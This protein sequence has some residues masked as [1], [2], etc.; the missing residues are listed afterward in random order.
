MA[1]IHGSMTGLKPAQ[2]EA[3]RR[4][5]RRKVRPTQVVSPELATTLCEVSAD[6]RRQIGVLLDRKGRVDQVMVGDADKIDLPDVGRHRAGR[7]RLRG[8]RLVHTHLRGESLTR[9][10]LTDLSRLRLDMVV[11][12]CVGAD[13]RPAQTHTAHLLPDNPAGELWDIAPPQSVHDLARTEFLDV[14]QALEAEFARVAGQRH[15]QEGE[16]AVLVQVRGGPVEESEAS[17]AEL[18][19]L[20]R[21]AGVSVADTVIQRRPRP[22]PRYMTGRGKVQDIIFRAMQKEAHCLIF[23]HDLTPGQ[24]R[25]LGD[26]T[27]F[28]VV[29]RTQLILDIF[30]Q[31]AHT[32]GGKL[33]VELAQL[34]YLLPRLAG[35]YTRLS[36]QGGGLAARGPG[37][38]KL[39]MDRR[40]IGDRITSLQKELRKLGRQREQRRSRRRASGVPVVAIV[41]YTNAGKSTLLNSLTRS[42]VVAEDMLFATLDPTTRRLRF[43]MDR[44]LVLA[45]TVGFIR[46]LPKELLEAFKATLEELGDADLLLHV[47]DA[48]DPAMEQ[49]IDAVDGILNELE[50]GDA[51]RLLALNKVD[52]LPEGEGERIAGRL[53]GV[54][55]SARDRASTRPLLERLERQLWAEG[56]EV[57]SAGG[58]P[59]SVAGQLGEIDIVEG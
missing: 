41:G 32:R 17:L 2:V 54:A 37:E 6:T 29:D 27:E 10:D 42:D 5:R 7:V 33:Q 9:D 45:D 53:D 50:I 8:L 15:A 18:V 22:D 59:A 43:P 4:L 55:V 36:R 12:L 23:D 46:D 51:P 39:E 20:C 11:A 19:E 24:A 26:L 16:R 14:V 48:A 34:R 47:V 28:K 44:E 25:A 56:I 57:A 38:K 35:R 13:G 52:L 58:V 31:H 49:R 40:R 1:D 3:L 21:T 30:A